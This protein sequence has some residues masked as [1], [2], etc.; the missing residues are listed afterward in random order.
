MVLGCWVF[1]IALTLSLSFQAEGLRRK[2]ADRKLRDE[3]GL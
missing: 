2:E 3:S 1:F